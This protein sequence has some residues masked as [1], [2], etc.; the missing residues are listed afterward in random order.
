MAGSTRPISWTW[1]RSTRTFEELAAYRSDDYRLTGGDRPERAQGASV[2]PNFFRLIGAHAALGRVFND[3]DRKAGSQPVTVL[4]HG[5]WRERFSADPSI[6]GRSVELDGRAHIVV[7]VLPE[8]F[9]FTLLGRANVWTPLVFTPEETSDRRSRSVIGLGRLRDGIAIDQA[10]AELGGIA[11][12]LA[13]AYPDTNATRGVRVL[14]LADEIRLHHDMGFLLPVLFG[15]V[16]C[17]L[18]IACVNVTNVMLARAS[19][20]RHE[21]AVRIALGASRSRIGR[22]WVIEHLIVFV[23][24]GAAGAALAVYATDWITASI[25]YREPWLPAELR[26]R[27]CRPCS[28]ALRAGRR[29]IVRHAVWLADGVDRSEGRCQRRPPGRFRPNDDGNQGKPT[30]RRPGGRR[31]LARARPAH[32]L[33]AARA[34]GPQHHARRRRVRLES[35]ADVSDAPR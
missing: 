8:S 14:R 29:R 11:A 30:A 31:S 2:T 28:A 20:R 22:Q 24:A 13:T 1:S 18:L 9:Q 32:Q 27:D 21:T 12:H 19:A 5:L 15:M 10:R 33:R 16:G 6:L 7:G 34:D 35:I 25:P 3:E 23:A 17:V 4:S 26:R